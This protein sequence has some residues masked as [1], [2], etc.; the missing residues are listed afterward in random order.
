M[1]FKRLEIVVSN[2]KVT[3]SEED[4][5]F[6]KNF[7][8]GYI[9]KIINKY[10]FIIASDDI[11]QMCNIALYNSINAYN[12]DKKSF[13]GYAKKIMIN[14]ILIYLRK[15]SNKS[16]SSSVE[17][18]KTISDNNIDLEEDIY[19]KDLRKKIFELDETE[20]KIINLYFF[21]KLPIYKISKLL[22]ISIYLIN[23]IKIRALVKLKIKLSY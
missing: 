2:F 12:T 22:N 17:I 15:K 18:E 3:K 8:K 19:I 4:F 11:E 7:F 16:T 21:K 14:D 20:F 10:K 6:I 13:Y 23:K 5:I 9:R 1:D